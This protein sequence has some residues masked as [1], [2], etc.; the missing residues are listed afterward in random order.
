MR[1]RVDPA[2]SRVVLGLGGT[3]DYEIRWDSLVVEGLVEEYGIVDAEISSSVT[4]GNERDLVVSLLGFLKEGVGGERPVASSDII[5]QF[6]ARFDKAV[7]LGGTCVRAAMGMEALGITSTIHLVSLDDDVRR[8]LPSGCAYISSAE[9]D[10][11]DP[12]LIVQ[13]AGGASVQRGDI[14][15]TVAHPN[16]L[17]Y[18]DD[19]PNR[20][21]VLSDEL[22][23]ALGNAEIFMISGFNCIVDE[24]LLHARLDAIAEY[25]RQLPDGAFVYFED[26]SYH[27]PEFGVLVRDAM[28]RIVDVYSMNEDEMQSYLGRA[29]DLLD[30]DDMGDALIEIGRLVRAPALVMHTKHWSLALG[31]RAREYQAALT[32]G[33]TMA[34]TR[35]SCGD[36]FTAA[37]YARVGALA[38]QIEGA[39]FA[40]GI[41]ARM[42]TRVCCVPALSMDV[43]SPTTIGLGDSFVGGFIASMSASIRGRQTS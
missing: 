17:I 21:L 7:T 39:A 33:V 2:A 23:P 37:D 29:V 32:G 40:K 41:A 30:V 10:T 36:G 3:V 22:G 12:H 4:I 11:T 16:R 35:Y 6:A 24:E 31:K 28:A 27:R 14:N 5:E 15:I 9:H 18:T 25:T 42:G 19:P 13:F 43:A 38:P 20:D 8:M 26:A 1:G 34:S